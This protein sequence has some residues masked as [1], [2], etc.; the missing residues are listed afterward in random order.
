MG[1]VRVVVV[2][3]AVAVVA[4]CGAGGTGS[5]S[6]VTYVHNAKDYSCPGVTAV[7]DI[8][9][10]AWMDRCKPGACI[11]NGVDP[12]N[13]VH[14]AWSCANQALYGSDDVTPKCAAIVYCASTDDCADG[15]F[16]ADASEAWDSI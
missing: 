8:E 11:P 13:T 6:R 5:S 12:K 4:G 10:L 1:I 9:G 16:C 14:L 3:L 2:V 7:P 15:T